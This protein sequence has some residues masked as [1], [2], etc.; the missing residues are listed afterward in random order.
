MN[1]LEELSAKLAKKV[2][3]DGWLCGP[4][5]VEEYTRLL[6]AVLGAQQKPVAILQL[7]DPED[8]RDGPWFSLDD[9]LQLRALPAGTKLFAAPVLPIVPEGWQ[10]IE[11]APEGVLVVVSWIDADDGEARHNFDY[12]EDGVWSNYFNEHEHYMIAGVARGRSEDAPYT[13]WTPLPPHWSPLP[14]APSPQEDSP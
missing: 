3:P 5:A 8:D 9:Y 1:S 4:Y 7:P 12:L 2:S 10:P 14:A 11:T 13:H 6:V